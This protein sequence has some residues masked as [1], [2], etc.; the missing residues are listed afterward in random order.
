MG[1]SGLSKSLSLPTQSLHIVRPICLSRTCCS[2]SG[3]WLCR[4]NSRNTVLWSLL[5]PQYWE[6]RFCRYVDLRAGLVC[7]MS[8]SKKTGVGENLREMQ[9]VPKWPQRRSLCFYWGPN[10]LWQ[11]ARPILH[12][13][14]SQ[15]LC[16]LQVCTAVPVKGLSKQFL[17]LNASCGEPLKSRT[18]VNSCGLCGGIQV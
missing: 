11:R 9:T 2:E 12:V 15:I 3:I 8:G 18:M 1:S 4:S 13:H 10:K 17:F 6:W 7:L 16:C 14:S 5:L